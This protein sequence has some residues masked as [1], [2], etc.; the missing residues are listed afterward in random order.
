MATSAA[1]K[2]S[3]HW[4]SQKLPVRP[5]ASTETVR[6]F[7][8]SH[9]VVLPVEFR[10]YFLRH[11]GMDPRSPNDKDAQ[12]FAFWQLARVRPAAQELAQTSPPMTAAPELDQYFAFADYLDWSWAYAIRLTTDPRSSSRVVL[13]GGEQ[14]IDVASSFGEFVDLYL[15]DSPR[16]YWRAEA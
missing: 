4:A 13:I 7:E 11:D 8:A 16:L 1:D 12:G 5:G 3:R 10:E 6:Q 9:N 14:A 2:L 15:R